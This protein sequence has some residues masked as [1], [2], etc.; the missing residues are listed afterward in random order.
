MYVGEH[1]GEEKLYKEK[2]GKPSGYM[3]LG[4]YVRGREREGEK[5]RERER[6]RERE[7]ERDR[8]RKR[9]REREKE[10]ERKPYHTCSESHTYKS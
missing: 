5:G 8:E 1:F 2:W 4:L 7:R 10:R 6:K 9:G 3:C